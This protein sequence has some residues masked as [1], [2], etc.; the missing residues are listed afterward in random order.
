M[1]SH[2]YT[3]WSYIQYYEQDSTCRSL[4]SKNSISLYIAL[5]VIFLTIKV[6]LC[7]KYHC[8]ILTLYFSMKNKPINPRLGSSGFGAAI[9]CQKITQTHC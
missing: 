1:N 6:H 9:S 7:Q 4:S 5:I 3:V 8:K 2:H